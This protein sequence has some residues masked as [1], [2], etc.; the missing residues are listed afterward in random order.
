MTTEAPAAELVHVV[1]TFDDTRVIDDL[2]MTVD[3][4]Q[5]FGLIGPSGCGKTTVI[6]MLVGVL[7]PTS[8]TVRVMGVEP[9]AFTTADRERIGYTPQG[10]YLYPTL[11]VK[12]NAGFVAGLYGIGWLRRRRRVREVLKFLE[13]WEARGRLARD[14]SGG[15]QRRL[16]LACAL[17]PR[18]EL[19]FVDEPT[20]G[21]DPVLREK[22]WAYLRRL[23]D[24]GTTVFVTTQYI[25]EAVYCD[26][27][28]VLTG[29]RLAAVGSPDALRRQALRGEIVEVDAGRLTSDDIE[30]LW[31]LSG[32]TRVEWTGRGAARLTVADA[33]A[34]IPA[35]TEALQA[36]G[37]AVTAV[38]PRVPTFD[39]V[40]MAIVGGDDQKR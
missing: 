8:G 31:R 1:K 13:L 18:P 2:T 24:Q 28:A 23:R 26:T 7:A 3:R 22:I 39:E 25:D 15:M 21:L 40:F 17:L 9:C 38:R 36:R 12:E 35:V 32:V 5:I 27:V 14:I 16:A 10:F 20:A 34:A 11:T 4:E 33:A 37:T 6:R 19:L 29:G 30:A